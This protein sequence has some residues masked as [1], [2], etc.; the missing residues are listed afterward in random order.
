[1]QISAS[2]LAADFANLAADVKAV[3]AAGADTVHFDV[4]DGHYVPD[5][6]VG[7]LVCKALRRSGVTA[8]IDVHLMVAHPEDFIEPFAAAG[9]DIITFHPETVSDVEATLQ[10]IKGRD[11]Q[12]GLVFNP[13][14]D[15]QVDPACWPLLDILMLMSVVPGKGGQSFITATLDKIATTRNMLLQ[16]SSTACLA[17]D[18]GVKVNNIQQIASA[19][20]DYF[21]VGSGL[22]AADDYVQ[23]VQELRQ[24]LLG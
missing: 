19:G 2:I 3:L 12:A 1:L 24:C 15:V 14:R 17:V 7:P 8:P 4:M 6:T 16:H 22:F 20:A 18:G 11:M 13:D 9:A 23:R 10:Q 5:L 21:V